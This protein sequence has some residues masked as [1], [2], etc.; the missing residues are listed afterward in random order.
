MRKEA[1][2]LSL[3]LVISFVSHYEIDAEEIE[4]VGTIS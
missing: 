4:D 1:I 2:I 3:L